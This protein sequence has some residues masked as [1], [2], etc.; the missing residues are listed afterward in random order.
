MMYA[1][2]VFGLNNFQNESILMSTEEWTIST[3]KRNGIDCKQEGQSVTIMLIA[4]KGNVC[5][6]R[7]FVD[8]LRRMAW[9]DGPLRGDPLWPLDVPAGSGRRSWS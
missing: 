5:P 6:K 4:R 1:F 8:V 7:L 2:S 9:T 3:I